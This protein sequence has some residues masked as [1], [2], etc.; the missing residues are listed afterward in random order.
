MATRSGRQYRDP[1]MQQEGETHESGGGGPG[2]VPEGGHVPVDA[3]SAGAAGGTAVL[4][5][6]ARTRPGQATTDGAYPD[7]RATEHAGKG[8]RAGSQGGVEIERTS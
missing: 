2:M 6:G 1:P 5:R 8:V 7:G 4:E 3:G